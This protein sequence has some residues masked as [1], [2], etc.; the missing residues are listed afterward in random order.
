MFPIIVNNSQ[1][2]N[3][4]CNHTIKETGYA[5]EIFGYEKAEYVYGLNRNF[6]F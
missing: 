2:I 4:W 1:P 5:I 6:C 3:I